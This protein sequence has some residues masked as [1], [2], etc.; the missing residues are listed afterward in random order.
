MDPVC[1]RCGFPAESDGQ[2]GQQHVS[3]ADA[4]VCGLLFGGGSMLDSL[5]DEES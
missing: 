1:P 3:R 2:G 4:L 5:L